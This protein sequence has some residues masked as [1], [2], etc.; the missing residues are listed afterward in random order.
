MSFFSTKKSKIAVTF[1][2]GSSSVGA[3]VFLLCP[4]QKPRMIYS[5]RQDMVFQQELEYGRLVSSMIE[6]LTDVSEKALRACG[7]QGGEKSV[8]CFLA[9]PWYAS[10][11]RISKKTFKTPIKVSKKLLQEMYKK[12]A[13]TFR[14]TEITRMGDDVEIF[15]IENIQT[16]LNGYETADPYDKEAS[17]VQIALYV[18]IAPSKIADTVRDRVTKKFHHPIPELRAFP[19]ASFIVT[20]DFFHEKN[21]LLLDISGEVTDVSVVRDNLLQETASFPCGKNF[22]LRK[23]SSALRCSPEEAIS[24]FRM[25][26]AG[27]LEDSAQKKVLDAFSEIGKEWR[28]EFQKTLQSITPTTAFLPHNVFIASDEDVSAW[29]SENIQDE[30][31]SQFYLSDQTFTVRHLNSKLLSPFCDVDNKVARDPFLILE[32]IFAARFL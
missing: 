10:Q 26:K 23:L 25:S 32:G 22:L 2:I 17:E 15:E 28:N 9:S 13:D 24:T 31:V 8:Y 4:D 3:A 20:R 30:D 18:S 29:F 16:K 5:D 14:E 1:D 12:E 7:S 19:F 21:F 27:L 11:T 6:K